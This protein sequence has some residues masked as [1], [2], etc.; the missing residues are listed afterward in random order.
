VC[1]WIGGTA[2]RRALLLLPAV[3]VSTPVLA[4]LQLG[5]FQLAVIALSMLAMISAERGRAALAGALLGVAGFKL[6]PGIFGLY[7]IARRRWSAAGWTIAFS[8]L[9]ALIAYLWLGPRPFE[10][11][12]HHL[13][14]RLASGEAWSFVADD[15]DVS[16][17]NDSVPGLV[18]KLKT[19]GVAG[20]SHATENAVGWAWTLLTFGLTVL[21]AWRSARM[22]RL[23][24]AA[25][26]L[27]IVTLAAF[28]SPFVPDIYGLVTPMWMLSLVLAARPLSWR[29]A[30]W[31]AL[32]WIVFDAVLP[33]GG[34]PLAGNARLLISTLS[35]VTALGLC[36]WVLCRGPRS[37]GADEP[38]R[39]S[40]AE[41]GLGAAQAA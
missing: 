25:S 27:G 33:F 2:G 17:I 7:L 21:A 29:T 26:W 37:A 18:L 4:T 11:Y 23:E 20:M 36:L 10:G 28:R 19:L 1:R 8:L 6:F 9:Y 41:P 16:A 13:L 5:N 35:Q 14:P 3:W 40:P 12:V 32:A 22:S 38:G 30:G 15:A 31:A 39:A 34:T 24:Q